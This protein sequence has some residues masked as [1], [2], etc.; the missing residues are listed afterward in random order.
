MEF[1]AEQLE[2]LLKSDTKNI[3]S[4]IVLY[5]TFGMFKDEAKLCMQELANRNPNES[6]DFQTFI[7][8]ECSKIKLPEQSKSINDYKFEFGKV[9]ADMII[10]SNIKNGDNSPTATESNIDKE[11][12]DDDLDDISNLF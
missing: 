11:E 10:S 1:T 2:N 5:K 9:V 7:K 3:A 12:E 6:F 8:E 4:L